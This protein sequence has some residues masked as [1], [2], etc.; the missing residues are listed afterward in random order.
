MS[1]ADYIAWSLV[2][3][4]LFGAIT[5]ALRVLGKHY[6]WAERSHAARGARLQRRL[7]KRL[8]RGSDRYFEE[9][10][11]ID[12]AIA[13]HTVAKPSGTERF[14]ALD[15]AIVLAFALFIGLL[16]VGWVVAPRLGLTVPPWSD[17]IG[18]YIMPVVGLQNVLLSYQPGTISPLRTRWMGIFILGMGTLIVGEQIWR[19]L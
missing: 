8:A 10:R 18:I 9:L 17:K 11:S 13:E 4:G 16:V 15:A 19:A 7:D 3:A 12:V 5:V 14:K 1:N 2:V 6:H